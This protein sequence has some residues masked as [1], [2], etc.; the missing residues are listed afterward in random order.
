MYF[1]VI[2]TSNKSI[3]MNKEQSGRGNEDILRLKSMP[4]YA[5]REVEMRERALSYL[6]TG[7]AW[8]SAESREVRDSLV[9]TLVSDHEDLIKAADELMVDPQTPAMLEAMYVR[10][11]EIRDSRLRTSAKKIEADLPTG[12]KILLTRAG[13]QLYKVLSG[14]KA[15]M[16]IEQIGPKM[17]ASG[18]MPTIPYIRG[19]LKDLRKA[20]ITSGYYIH[21]NYKPVR[22]VELNYLLKERKKKRTK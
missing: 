22:G 1:S 17:D 15:P 3:Y 4:V 14:C 18:L 5:N 7:Q 9:S 13:W 2:S 8:K 16:S 11:Q 6:F 10:Q 12:E 20:L 21:T 19:A